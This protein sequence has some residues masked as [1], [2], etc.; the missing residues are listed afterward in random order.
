MT[1]TGPDATH[2]PAKLR[3]G[4]GGLLGGGFGWGAVGGGGG[5]IGGRAG[6]G[7]KVVGGGCCGGE[8]G[9]ARNPLLHTYLHG[10]CV[11]GGHTNIAFSGREARCTMG[12]EAWQSGQNPTW[13]NPSHHWDHN[14]PKPGGGGVAYKDRAWSPPP[15]SCL[16]GTLVHGSAVGIATPTDRIISTPNFGIA[17]A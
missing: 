15:P 17:L 14:F 11:Y 2:P 1:V 9:P 7:G 16:H 13:S 10:V 3:G 6:R 4:G 12:P 5:G 8:G